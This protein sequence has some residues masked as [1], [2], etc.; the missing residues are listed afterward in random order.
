MLDPK[1]L[2]NAID[3]VAAKLGKRGFKL[4]IA[5][6]NALEEKRKTFQVR[7]QELQNDRNIRS[8]EVGKAKASG[9]NVDEVLGDLKKLSEELKSAE[10]QYA[11]IQVELDEYFDNGDKTSIPRIL[12]LLLQKS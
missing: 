10:E 8:K 3:E 4:D 1:L 2:R 5:K 6:V 9:K 12:T 7:M 11:K